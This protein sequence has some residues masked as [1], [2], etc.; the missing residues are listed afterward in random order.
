VLNLTAG[1]IDRN[2]IVNEAD[3]AAVQT[4]FGITTGAFLDKGD[5][6][7]DGDVDGQ[8]LLLVQ[9]N[10]GISSTPSASVPEPSAAMLAA[11][12]ALA[13]RRRRRV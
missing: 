7:M 4:N 8:D 2:G 5:A 3:I 9:R 6:D 10:L 13:L 12:G 1:D 11:I